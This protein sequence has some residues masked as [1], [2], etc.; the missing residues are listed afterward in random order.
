MLEWILVGAFAGLAG[1]LGWVVVRWRGD[2]REL[3]RRLDVSASQLQNLQLSFSRFAPGELIERIINDGDQVRGQRLEVTVL[4]ADLAGFTA[5]S[6]RTAPDVLV[7]I[8]NGYFERMSDAISHHRGHV[9]TFIG[10][11]I[12]ALF[13]ALSPNP[14]QSDDAV[15]AA[16]AMRATLA[17][18][19]RE[20][21]ADGLPTL[22]VGIG[23]HRGTGI[24]GL[25]GSRELMEF[26]VV[27]RTINVAARVQDLTR[28]FGT[29]IL[30]TAQL[31]AKLDPRFA[32]RDLPAT[33]VKGV[34]D[35]IV[36]HAVEGYDAPSGVAGSA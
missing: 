22:R 35:A 4:F 25:V 36:I 32:V 21:E 9:S 5:L 15:H 13:G 26:T 18:Y 29:D 6:E 23:L 3:R 12:L 34:K 7:Q 27:G 17:E 20:L 16:L 1:V 10:D 31:R 28:Q 8:L 14:W 19:N 2:V 33:E 24:A 11:G 30:I